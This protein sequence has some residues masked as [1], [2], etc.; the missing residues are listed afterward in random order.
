MHFEVFCYLEFLTAGKHFYEAHLIGGKSA[1]CREFMMSDNG[2][3]I[4]NDATEL[5]QGIARLR[6]DSFPFY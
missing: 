3:G 5:C 4:M 2:S 1:V 6:S